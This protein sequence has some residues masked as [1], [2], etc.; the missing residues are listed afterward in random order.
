MPN[1]TKSACD[2]SEFLKVKKITTKDF[3]S[4]SKYLIIKVQLCESACAL[5]KVGKCTG[6]PFKD[7]NNFLE[8]N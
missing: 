3:Y 5:Q 7:C 4:L 2:P 8:D 6:V 1:G